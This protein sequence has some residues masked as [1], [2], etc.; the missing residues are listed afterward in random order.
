MADSFWAPPALTTC[1][2]CAPGGSVS[3]DIVRMVYV[4]R[5]VRDRAYVVTTLL[6]DRFLGM[7]VLLL[8]GM[9]AAIFSRSYLPP[10]VLVYC[11]EAVFIVAVFTSLFLMSEYLAGRLSALALRLGRLVGLERLGLGA[12]RVLEA[13]ARISFRRYGLVSPVVTEASVRNFADRET[14]PLEDRPQPRIR[15]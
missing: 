12:S 7:F 1:A 13:D 5:E 9:L 4:N 3:T 2:A 15:S 11:I 6:Y 14:A 8:V 10:G